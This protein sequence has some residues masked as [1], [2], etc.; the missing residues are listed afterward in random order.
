MDNKKKKKKIKSVETLSAYISYARENVQPVLSDAAA[1]HLVESY[2]E[3]RKLGQ[4]SKT[5]TATPRQLESLIRLS[6]ALAKMKL[7]K[8]VEIPDV[9]E[10]VRLKTKAK[11]KKRKRKRKRKRR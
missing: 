6:E 5:I 9:D 10:A 8:T 1:R 4:G 11:T 2:V 3:M 7:S